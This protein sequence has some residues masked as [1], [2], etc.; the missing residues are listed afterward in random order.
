MPAAHV[1]TATPIRQGSRTRWLAGFGALA[2][3]AIGLTLSWHYPIAPSLMA[4]FFAGFITLFYLWPRSCLLLI[5]AMLPVIGF[6]PWTG[7]LTFEEL[8]LLVLAAATAGYVRF[9]FHLPRAASVTGQAQAEAPQRRPKLSAA[10]LLLVVLFLASVLVAMLRGFVDAGGFSFGWFQGYHEPMNS[11]RLAKSFMEAALLVPLWRVAYR[12]NPE[13]TQNLLSQGLMLGLAAAALT[14][15]WERAAFTGLL[16]FSSDYRTTG[17][18]WE[19]HVGGAAL[20][21]FLALT[22]PF[23][24][25][26]LLLARTPAR[27]G[28]AA[29]V[30]ALA[31]YAC[32]TT[33]SRGVY[34]AIPVGTALFLTLHSWQ[35]KQRTTPTAARPE[36]AG[37]GT[38]LVPA[39]LLLVGFGVGAAWIFPTSGYRGMAALLATAALMLP[40]ARVLRAFNFSH[41]L[42]GLLLGAALALLAGASAWLLPKG[43]YIAWGLAVMLTA[44]MLFW[45]RPAARPAAFAGPLA[46]ASFLATVAGTALVANH[47]GGAAG[48]RHAAPVL[49]VVLGACLAAGASRQRLWPDALRWQATTVGVMGLAAAIV[50]IF[51]G[52]SYM[53]DR[54][55]T[56]ERDLG[57]RLAHWQLGR[58]MLRAP[59]DWWLGKGLG[60]FP[61][62]Y[63]LAG[64]PQEHPGDYRLK[65]ES[66]N[67]YITLTG[68]LHINGWGEIFRLTQRVA[69]P[70]HPAIVT[71]RVRTG[72]AVSLH[73]EVCEKHL[74]YSQGCVG[75]QI[76]IKGAPGVWQAVRLELQ[77]DHV[78]RGDWYAPRLLAFSMAM[79]S[80]GGTADLDDVTL[81]GA[82]GRQLLANGDFSDRMAHWFFSSDRYHLPWHIKS[83]FMNVLFDQGVVGATLWGLLLASALWRTTLG[84]ARRHPLAPALAAS[85]TGFAVVGMFDS[86]LDV[87]RLG[88]L[89]YFLVLLALTLRA[90]VGPGKRIAAAA[91]TEGKAK[92]IKRPQ[93]AESGPL[94]S[95]PAFIGTP[96]LPGALHHM[97][98]TQP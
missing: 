98:P 13:T 8:D 38:Y 83:M 18:F 82:D 47:W 11:V 57:S 72:K 74:L 2:C 92:P 96:H 73:F 55:S 12:K 34:L 60:R 43:A 9:A 62:N 5:P 97:R 61:A 23:A 58:D 51:D 33:F 78:T 75:R 67:T 54:F 90:V 95:T 44:A 17:L 14:T 70:G 40:L 16:N 19:M 50:G 6:A 79:A 41:W 46:L 22:V 3:G 64:K 80:R 26:E 31:A 86:L 91:A 27:W 20:D 76:D 45:L 71:A 56:G 88:W 81:T 7:W 93:P 68:G 52:G 69:E 37:S 24:L 1:L 36:E 28:V 84:T 87:P 15:V 94:P 39:L 63:F 4:V 10:H 21:G 42:L 89:F 25:R 59:A 35:Q 65:H 85:L 49:L 48:L 66:E 32:L 77:G 29:T 53:G 30:L